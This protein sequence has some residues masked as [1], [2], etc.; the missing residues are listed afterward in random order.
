MSTR[1]DAI[2]LDRACEDVIQALFGHTKH[3]DL[4]GQHLPVSEAAVKQACIDVY[5]YDIRKFGA[6]VLPAATFIELCSNPKWN[7][8]ITK[9]N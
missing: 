5:Y 1:S 2:M 9:D 3:G 8:K 7:L 4:V 6:A